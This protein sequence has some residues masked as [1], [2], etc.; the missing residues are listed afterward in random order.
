MEFGVTRPLQHS[1]WKQVEKRFQILIL[2]YWKE[3]WKKV[4]N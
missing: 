2:T 3:D 4:P 1:Q